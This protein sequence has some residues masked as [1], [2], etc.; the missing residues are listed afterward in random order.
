MEATDKQRAYMRKLGIEFSSNITSQ[1]ASALIKS[2]VGDKAPQMSSK[3]KFDTSSYYVAYAKDVFCE[4]LKYKASK[5]QPN[6]L[7]HYGELMQSAIA[8]I[9]NAKEAFSQNS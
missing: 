7:I 5:L 3:A 2:K 1:E 6:E 8:V 9:K 4:M